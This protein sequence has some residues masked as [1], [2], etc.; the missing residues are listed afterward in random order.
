MKKSVCGFFLALAFA[1]GLSALEVN[2]PELEVSGDADA[3]Q[4]ENYGG[5][6]AVI[7]SAAAIVNIGTEL[8][9]EVAQSL[10][11]F[12]SVRPGA[13]YSLIHAVDLS[14]AEKLDADILIL[15]SNAG[16]DHIKN[17]RRI[18]TG[19]LQAAYGYETADAEVIATFITV[20]NAVYRKDIG[21]FEERYKQVVLD[22]ITEDK[23]GLSTNWAD[24]AGNTEIVIPLNDVQSGISAVDTTVISDENVVNALR[25]EDDKAVDLREDMLEIK[26][27]ETATAT[28]KAQEAQKA[29]AQERKEGNKEQAEEFA[30]ESAEQQ[31]I[32][33]RKNEE[34]KVEQKVLE[35]DKK[36]LGIA[37]PE[38]ED[39]SAYLTGL[40]VVNESSN[41]YTLIT[42][43]GITG[44][45]VRKSP[46]NQI[47]GKTV[48]VVS[49]ITITSQDNADVYEFYDDMYLAMCGVNDG[50]SAPRL[51]L[52]DSDALEL[53]K[54]SA[55]ILSDSSEL[56]VRDG[57]YYVVVK[58]DGKCHVASYSKD[59]VLANMSTLEVSPSTPLNM[60]ASG[61]LVTDVSGNPRML[62]ASL[63]EVW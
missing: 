56:A 3:I 53:K 17:L 44:A 6:H 25:Q 21:T 14:V 49:D 33:D 51:C 13:K 10:E 9:L 4:F 2:R 24:W 37:V 32:A 39:K 16:V 28:E 38:V 59:L 12:V 40:F 27:K 19:Y 41:L 62:D 29:A 63:N 43:N 60:M 35:E 26:E 57:A 47:K 55:E 54:Q 34:V 22:N 7:D 36:E 15:N 52:I 42:V 48:F 45:V 31:E 8:G 46:V 30:K 23:V 50:H 11:E 61:I 18:I 5:P 1:A 20:Y 58:V